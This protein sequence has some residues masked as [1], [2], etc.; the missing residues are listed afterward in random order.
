M[1]THN[2][3]IQISIIWTRLKNA[4]KE[5]Y[6][7]GDKKYSFLDPNWL[8][9]NVIYRWVKNSTGE[10]AEIGESNRRLSDK[11]SRYLS[12][13]P[14]SSGGAPNKK[15]YLEQQT[16]SKN[17]D[18]LYLEITDNIQGFNLDDEKDRKLAV[19]F[20]IGYTKPYLQ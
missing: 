3:N 1:P 11:V 7:W 5:P 15:V 17:D 8:K 10:I 12:A 16:L 4:K 14:K 19:S 18:Y 20:L 6:R 9:F 2:I 13:S